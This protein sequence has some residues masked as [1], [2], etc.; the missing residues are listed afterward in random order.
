ME[1]K[2]I[3]TPVKKHQVVLKSFITGRESREIKG[4]FLKGVNFK[5]EGQAAKS[6]DIDMEKITEEAEN[7]A[8]EIVV[9]S[10]NG[11]EEKK[12]DAILDMNLRDYEFVKSEVN[13]ITSGD[14]FLEKSQTQNSGGDKGK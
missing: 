14:D 11:N 1:T 10:I 12:L 3:E 6:D 7:K 4:V 2:T 8:F 5:L 13:K 9:I